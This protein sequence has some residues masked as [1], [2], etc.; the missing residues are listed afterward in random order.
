MSA[1]GRSKCYARIEKER[2][3]CEC[4]KAFQRR[5]YF[6]SRA[7][8]GWRGLDAGLG[9]QD[10]D[11]C[12]WTATKTLP[13][14]PRWSAGPVAA[15]WTLQIVENVEYQPG[16]KYGEKKWGSWKKQWGE[17]EPDVESSRRHSNAAS[18]VHVLTMLALLQA[19]DRAQ[20]RS[21]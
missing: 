7:G 6:Y 19:E 8:V 11:S 21:T 5:C 20:I 3:S 17:K 2:S 16:P 15:V 18:Q 9:S 14:R 12:L 1:G 4:R 10:L 13:S